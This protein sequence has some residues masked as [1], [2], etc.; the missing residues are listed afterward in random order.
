[1]GVSPATIQGVPAGT[2]A[3]T[4]N[5]LITDGAVP[6]R[7][8]AAPSRR[9]PKRCTRNYPW[10]VSDPVQLFNDLRA[11]KQFV[12]IRV[13]SWLTFADGCG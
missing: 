4:E 8:K 9:T 10:C 3:S 6:T 13:Y 12:F 11:A 1:M 7:S 5:G 2:A